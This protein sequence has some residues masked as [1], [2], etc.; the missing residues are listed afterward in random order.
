M[1][2]EKR[3]TIGG[4]SKLFSSST[5]TYKPIIPIYTRAPNVSLRYKEKEWGVFV[6]ELHEMF[7]EVNRLKKLYTLTT[8]SQIANGQGRQKTRKSRTLIQKPNITSQKKVRT[9]EKTKIMR[10]KPTRNTE[11]T[12]VKDRCPSAKKENTKVLRHT[13][14]IKTKKAYDIHATSKPNII[15]SKQTLRP[16]TSNVNLVRSR[17]HFYGQKRLVLQPYKGLR[18]VFRKKNKQQILSSNRTSRN[19]GKHFSVCF[20]Y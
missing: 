10:K 17:G 2:E 14:A 6:T 8:P 1:A 7:L 3:T 19:A 12:K 20:S 18:R 13:S 4:Q 11:N 5:V 9:T 15:H 16:A